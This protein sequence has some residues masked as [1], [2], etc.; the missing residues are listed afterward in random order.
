MKRFSPFFVAAWMLAIP[1]AMPMRAATPGKAE[2]PRVHQVLLKKHCFDCHDSGSEEAGVDLETISYEI[3]A[4]VENAELW[5]KVLNAINSGEMPPEDSEPLSDADKAAFLEDLTGQMVLAR[6]ILG[7]SGGVIPLRRLNRREYANTVEAL[8]GVRPDT[9]SLPDDQVGAGFDTQG[10]SLFFSS[11]QLE[12]YLAAATK[13]LR[14]CLLPRQP[15]QLATRRVDPE[16]QQS[17]HYQKYLDGIKDEFERATQWNAQTDKP[18]SEFGF[19]DRYQAKKKLQQYKQWGPQLEEYLARPET[20]TGSTLIMTIKAG[21]MTRVKLPVLNERAPGKYTVRFR[22]AHYPDADERFHYVELSS[23]IGSDRKYRGWRKVTGTLDDPQVIE[24]QFEHLPGSKE[25]L[26]LHQRSHQDRGDK[27]LWTI[28]QR[29]NGMGTKPGVWI[30][31]AEVEGPIVANAP[32]EAAANILFDRPGDWN[33]DR[34][35]TEVLRRF[36]AKAFRGTPPEPG[37]LKRLFAHYQSRREAGDSLAESLVSPL[38]I[39]LTSPEFL[40]LVETEN[41]GVSQQLRDTETAVRLSY[42]L[43]SS[44]PDDELMRVARD[45]K[46]RDPAVLAAQTDRLLSDERHQRFVHGFV[47]QWLGMERL[48]MFQFSGVDFPTFD[49]A[50]RENAREEIFQ[51]FAHIANHDQPLGALLDSDFVVINDVMAG[52][53]G[54]PGV[55]GHGFRKVPVPAGMP[56]GG[57]LGTAAVMAMGS[58]GLRSS[59]VERGAWVLRHLLNDPPAPAPPNVPQLSRLAGQVLSARELQKAH[60]EQPQCAQC[61][62]K[63]DPIGY[64]LENFAADGL[65]RE[66]EVLSIG[67]R[68][69]GRPAKTKSFDIDASGT[70][71]GGQA[72]GDFFGLRKAVAAHEDDFARG[73][74][75]SLIAYGLGRPYGFSDQ[76]LADQILSHA[77]KHHYQVN[78]FIHALIQSRAFQSR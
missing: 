18:P 45:G 62:R 6:K 52:Y 25:Q 20:K 72:F 13:T 33:D 54:I 53:Y 76:A 50:A 3:S 4:S 8:L 78:P 71:P 60:Q 31:W 49:N 40:Y 48:G 55:D 1:L 32:A 10:A 46:L 61:H 36:A 58:D 42:F 17:A 16:E 27:N 19:L 12:N 15:P 39:I 56:R 65:W 41:E 66:K 77:K 22:A 57:L 70:L 69:Y 38:A 73:F 64:G 43:W 74:T 68:F 5:Q 37:F 51:T 21:G 35:A 67:K 24:L 7:D 63:I 23:G 34:Y 30:D 9:M 11:D 59:P 14:L 26:W 47:H 75:E 29:E 44:S 2:M 28:H